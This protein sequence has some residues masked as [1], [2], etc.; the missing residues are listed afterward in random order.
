[1]LRQR[2]RNIFESGR[3]AGG[4]LLCV[5]VCEH[6]TAW[7]I[8]GHAPPGN[9]SKSDALRSVLRHNQVIHLCAQPDWV[10]VIW[11]NHHMHTVIQS[12]N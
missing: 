4:R 6:T 7:G 5:S 12:S 1:M 3:G 9:V 8:W 11:R 10:D 2:R